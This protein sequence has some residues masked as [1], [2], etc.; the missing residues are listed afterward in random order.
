MTT[1]GQTSGPQTLHQAALGAA[2]AAQHYRDEQAGAWE[3]VTR[4]VIAKEHGNKDQWHNVLQVKAATIAP[5]SCGKCAPANKIW[6]DHYGLIILP[7]SMSVTTARA[8]R[9]GAAASVERR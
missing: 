2:H 4:T 9:T 8:K 3:T 5:P 1:L 6:Y 7:I